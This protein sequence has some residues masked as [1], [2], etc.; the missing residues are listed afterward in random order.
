[1]QTILTVDDEPILRLL[2]HDM[3]ASDELAVLQAGDADEAWELLARHHPALVL[4]DVAL[5]GRSGLELARAIKA[6]PELAGTP[7]ILL[8]ALA[9]PADRAAG[10][11]AG[12]D[13]Y[14]SKPFSPSELLEIVGQRLAGRAAAM[15]G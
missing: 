8:S 15:A 9:L 14:V 13:L 11:A 1:M 6:D 7:V 4:L 2:V 3:L 5:P 10:L 12:A